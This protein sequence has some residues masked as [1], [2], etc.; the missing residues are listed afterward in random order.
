MGAQEKLLQYFREKGYYLNRIDSIEKFLE[1][2]A[3]NKLSEEDKK[4]LITQAYFARNSNIFNKS[5]TRDLAYILGNLLY[6]D[7]SFK[8]FHILKSYVDYFNALLIAYHE[9]PAMNQDSNGITLLRMILQ[10]GIGL[11]ADDF[12]KLLD[13]T[14][15]V[16]HG[17]RL[18]R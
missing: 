13:A 11:N 3:E 7:S 9:K 12:S 5:I 14:E 10:T 2:N 17:I 4:R 15:E 16:N 1:F 18:R 6:P 8:D